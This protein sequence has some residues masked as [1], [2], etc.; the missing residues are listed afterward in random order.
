MAE[1][2]AAGFKDVSEK[3]SL[4]IV[5]DETILAQPFGCFRK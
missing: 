2:L 3:F 5:E 1:I 4:T